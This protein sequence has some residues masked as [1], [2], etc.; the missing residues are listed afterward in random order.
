M[1]VIGTK[2]VTQHFISETINRKEK[3]N[4]KI[5]KNTK[6]SFFLN[7]CCVYVLYVFCVVLCVG[8]CTGHFVMV[9]LNLTYLVSTFYLHLPTVSLQF[10]IP[11]YEVFNVKMLHYVKNAISTMHLSSYLDN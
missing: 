3:K 4:R 11:L 2:A 6:N 8:F 10:I 1:T 7:V 5:L 9:L